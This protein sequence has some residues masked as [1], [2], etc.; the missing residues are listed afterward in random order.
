MVR[1]SLPTF[2]VHPHLS[3][4]FFLFGY[5]FDFM[6]CEFFFKFYELVVV[7]VE[8]S[9]LLYFDFI[10]KSTVTL[11]ALVFEVLTRW[12]QFA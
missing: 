10:A 7:Y 3:P 2:N 9:W 1:I 5:G 4:L 12:L 8:S 11:I 6:N